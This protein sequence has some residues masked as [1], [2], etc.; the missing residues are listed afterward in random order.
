MP[1]NFEKSVKGATKIKLAAPKSKYIEHILLATRS[2]EAGVA[3]IFRTLQFRLRDSTWT[4]VFKSLIVLHLMIREGAEPAALEYLSENPRKIAISSFSEVQSQGANIRRYSD[5]FA[6]RARAFADSK[7]DY[8]R[9]GQGRLKRLTVDKGLLRETE[10]VQKQIKALLKCDLLTDEVENEI[11]LTAFR[12]LTLDLLALYSV[13]N[14]GT[15]SVLENYFEM[16]R[17]DSERALKIYKTFGVQT[18]EVVKFLGVARHFEYATRLEIPNLKHASTDLVQLLEDDLNDPDFDL[19]RREHRVQSDGKK[20][21]R[22]ASVSKSPVAS[23]S[24][25]FPSRPQTAPAPKAEN[26][27]PGGDLIDFFGSIESNPPQ[28]AQQQPNFQQNA[29]AQST[30]QQQPASFPSQQTGFA[31]QPQSQAGYS[32]QTG[33]GGGFGQQQ[34]TNPFA[35]AQ[36]PQAAPAQQLQAQPTGAGFGG[37]GPQS[38]GFQSTLPTIAQNGVAD[39]P[40]QQQ[41]QQGVTNGFQPQQNSFQPQQNNFQPS[42]QQNNFQ[43]QQTAFQP[44]QTSL[45]PQRTATNPFRASMV[46]SS[47]TGGPGGFN[48]A[49]QAPQPLNRQN[50]NPFAKRLSTVPTSNTPPVPQIPPFQQSQQPAAQQPIQPQRTGTNPFARQSMAPQAPQQQQTLQP[51]QPNPTGSTNP[52]RQSAFI[53]QQTGQGWQA[54]GQHG[55]MGGFEQ[56]DTVPVFP[57]PGMA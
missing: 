11:T 14:E 5:Y 40:Q 33:F 12:L 9:S 51:L 57:R 22:R 52:F 55:T 56:L 29:F 2:G 34:N 36:Q 3:E 10:I 43:P 28:T 23:K 15:I 8:V 37:Y 25:T 50:T 16:S 7:I 42:Q 49:G 19:R 39:F 47:Q 21:G 6:A 41:Q 32:Q 45:M 20:T 13:M 35:Q 46:I 4:I 27:A 18:E 54:A 1:Q 53:N 44:Q 24:N 38:Y 30:F 17:P 26:K 31:Q 48:Q